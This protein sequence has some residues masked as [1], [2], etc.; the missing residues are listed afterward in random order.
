MS[1][2]EDADQILPFSSA[3]HPFRRLTDS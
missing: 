2:A 1:T 3:V